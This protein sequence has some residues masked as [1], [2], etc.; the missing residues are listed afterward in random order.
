[1]S[2]TFLFDTSM[3]FVEPHI[4]H[5]LY[6]ILIQNTFYFFLEYILC[7]QCGSN[8]AD[9]HYL[10]NHSSPTS[11]V[12]SNITLFGKSGVDIQTLVNPIGI[13]FKIVTSAKTLC[14]GVG[15]V[16]YFPF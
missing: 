10:E 12:Y 3:L 9:S 8:I 6:Y 15:D 1:M 5:M 11:T 7:R 13:H 4:D 16:S 2:N 14:S